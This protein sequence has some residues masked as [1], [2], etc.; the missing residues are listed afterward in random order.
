M[1]EVTENPERSLVRRRTAQCKK[2]IKSL[3]A[4]HYL[5]AG[6]GFGLS[7][8]GLL[9]VRDAD[10]ALSNKAVSA[11]LWQYNDPNKKQFR[12]DRSQRFKSSRYK[13]S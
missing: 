7:A 2:S 12:R 13:P 1:C 9:A 3:R 4:P 10:R 11:L 5:L 6:K 8:F